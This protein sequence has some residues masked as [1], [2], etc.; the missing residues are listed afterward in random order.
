LLS[1]LPLCVP[2]VIPP[3][4]QG[5]QIP[6]AKSLSDEHDPL[7]HVSEKLPESLPVFFMGL[8]A[9]DVLVIQFAFVVE[10]YLS[11]LPRHQVIILIPFDP[12]LHKHTTRQGREGLLVLLLA[13]ERLSS[14][15]V[16]RHL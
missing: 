14:I 11:F 6:T 4:G 9:L 15:P 5:A 16:P 8:M 12:L 10:T 2:Y 1:F 3:S 7:L 13:A